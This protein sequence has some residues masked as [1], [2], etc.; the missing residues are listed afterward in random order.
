P[1]ILSYET[2]PSPETLEQAKI[3]IQQLEDDH[4]GVGA[5]LK[6]MRELTQDYS[7]P[8]WACRTY[9]LAFQKLEALESDLFQHIHLENNILF[10]R[11][12]RMAAAGDDCN[13]SSH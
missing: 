10:P 3:A 5:L 11:I 8:E 13:C 4:A 9:T 2:D 1:L 6:T 12:E 7:L